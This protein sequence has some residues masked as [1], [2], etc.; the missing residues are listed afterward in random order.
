MGMGGM[1][2]PTGALRFCTTFVGTRLKKK[3]T[4]I[5]GLVQENNP[6]DD[7]ALGRP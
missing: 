6:P 3:K 7:A 2:S 1:I 5:K 4:G